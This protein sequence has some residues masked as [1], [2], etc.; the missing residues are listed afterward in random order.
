LAEWELLTRGTIGGKRLGDYTYNTR[1]FFSR[2]GRRLAA[3]N[4]RFG[5]TVWEGE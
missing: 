2:D 5:A 4:S 1:L 3:N